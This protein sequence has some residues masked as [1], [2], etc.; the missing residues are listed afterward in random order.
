[1][2]DQQITYRDAGVDIDAANEAVLRMR[3]H[4]R[5]TFNANV[6]TD[7]GT[8]GGMFSLAGISAYQEPVLV[9]SIDGVGTKLK[10][11][12]QVGRYESIGRDLVNHCV[13]DILVQGAQP[14]FFLDYFATGRL[15]PSVAVDVV[16]GLAESCRETGC[17][18]IGGE[19]AE[20][21][22][23]YAEGDFDLAGCIV[24]L[25][26]RPRI[27]DGS[28]IEPG[29]TLLGIASSGI[30]TNGFS[31]AR[32]ILLDAGADSLSLYEPVPMLGRTLAEELLTVHR[33]YAPSIVPLL[34]EF[35]IKGMAHITGGGFYDNVP[36]ILPVD[37]SATIERRTWPVPPIFSL[38]QE[39]GQ[40]PDPEMFRTFNMGIGIVVVVPAE[41]AP[42]LAHRLNSAGE[43][44][45]IIGNIHRGVHE[46]DII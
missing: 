1:M 33:C 35:D 4:I 41:Q 39:R 30:H 9:S 31:L 11:A 21:P 10:V 28:R 22:G 45:Y 46:V 40:V 44:A 5:S 26:D 15:A 19:T 29:D 13:N 7:V 12:I 6:L 16:R 23:V 42:A 38:I 18:L 37:C 34:G 27:I 36:R 3:D 32:R 20:M 17:A 24:G 43:S 25:V 2:T 8:F 14:L